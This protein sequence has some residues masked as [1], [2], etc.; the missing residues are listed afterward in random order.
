MVLEIFSRDKMSD[1]FLKELTGN[2][3]NSRGW[4]WNKNWKGKGKYCIR[5]WK[6]V[7]VVLIGVLLSLGVKES[8]S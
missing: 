3:E 5:L 2:K 4:L 8:N 7:L 6:I 1:A